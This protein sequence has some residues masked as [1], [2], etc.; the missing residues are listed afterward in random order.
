ME[1]SHR[2]HAAVVDAD[3]TMVAR[4]GDPDRV[5]FFR[6]SAKPFQAMPLV[7]DGVVDRFG[8]TAAELAICCA[9]HNAEEGH[10]QHVHSILERGGI[11]PV[12]LEC[13]PH[14]PYHA[15]AALALARSG[16]DPG[17][18]HNNCSGK[19]AGMLLLATHHGWTLSGYV[20]P[21]H[22]VQQ[23]MLEEV[24]RWTGLPRASIRTGIDGCGVV[25]F[26]VP[27]SAMASAYARLARAASKGEPAR[28]I[29]D[30]MV[31]HPFEVAG[32]GRLC[33][34]LM[35][36]A[37]PNVLA[38]LGAEGVYGAA[39]LARDWGV[40]IKVEDGGRRALEVA[41]VEILHALGALS[42]DALDQL[43]AFTRPP[44]HNTRGEVV[45]AIEPAFEVVWC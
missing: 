13:G 18:I 4:V 25:C 6:S 29:V 1:S 28:R 31:S 33:T 27:V 19:H 44:V 8:V 34:Q 30:A 12:A 17:R 3:G 37:Q 43:E 11:D 5:T 32:T 39:W 35:R 21:E 20:A 40:A 22:P 9:S 38:K 10:V 16:V 2:V 36:A 42:E 41:L 7:E 15:D 26:A 45:G 23:R 14:A 24:S